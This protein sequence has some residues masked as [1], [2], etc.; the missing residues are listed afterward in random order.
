MLSDFKHSCKTGS[1]EGRSGERR[2]PQ[3]GTGRP[4][5]REAATHE[6]ACEGQAEFRY[7]SEARGHRRAAAPGDRASPPGDSPVLS[8][9]GS[10]GPSCKGRDLG[11]RRTWPQGHHTWH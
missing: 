10:P 3:V 9:A 7:G 8:L 5:G 1:R 4:T 2:R 11:L 6:L